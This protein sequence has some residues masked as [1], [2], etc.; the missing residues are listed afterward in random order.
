MTEKRYE[1]VGTDDFF[2]HIQDNSFK[3]DKHEGAIYSIYEV[4]KRLNEQD[5]IIQELKNYLLHM[6]Y[7][8]IQHNDGHISLEAIEIK[9]MEIRNG[10]LDGWIE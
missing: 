6:G 4:V 7:K 9:K 3:E 8:T 2:Q 10:L 1:I 5:K